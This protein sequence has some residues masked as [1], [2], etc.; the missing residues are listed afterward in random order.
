MSL[1]TGVPTTTAT[2]QGSMLLNLPPEIRDMIYRYLVKG[3]YLLDVYPD[4]T[5]SR[6]QDIAVNAELTGPFVKRK[7]IYSDLNILRVSKTISDEAMA[8]LYSESTFR[9]YVQFNKD[10]T[11]RL[12]STPALKRMMTI[13]LCVNVHTRLALASH[14]FLTGSGLE[15]LKS[16]EE[17]WRSTLGC[18]TRTNE[19]RKSLHIRWWRFWFASDEKDEND[20]IP[21]WMFRCLNSM[22][23]FRNVVLQD[24]LYRPFV[25][26]ERNCLAN[27]QDH[28]MNAIEKHLRPAL[29]PA[30]HRRQGRAVNLTFHPQQHLTAISKAQ[31]AG[32]IAKVDELELEANKTEECA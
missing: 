8:I 4:S 25:G 10:Q 7:I 6:F 17:I 5:F 16:K 26:E 9:I 28:E 30:V 24:V 19:C 21:D 18:I 20:A 27:E 23:R 3:T 31:A 13:E 11:L 15:W 1:V 32:L 22:T 2:K 29:G 14:A 12:W